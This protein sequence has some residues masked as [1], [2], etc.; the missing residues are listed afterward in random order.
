MNVER[1][2]EIIA[3]YGGDPARWPM[4]EREAALQLVEADAQLREA[5]RAALR[6]DDDLLGWS[7]DWTAPQSA[8]AEA[9]TA[10]ARVLRARPVVRPE[11]PAW[12]WAVGTGMAAA[13][14]A[15]IALT[16]SFTAPVHTRIAHSAT[17]R[18]PASDAAAFAMVFTPTPD[19]DGSI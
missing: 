17:Y 16:S 11:R 4:Q 6:L 5:R 9:A 15:G 7:Q 19:E 8:P 10:A 12:R 14:A 2:A 3:A 1:A 13:L 18:G